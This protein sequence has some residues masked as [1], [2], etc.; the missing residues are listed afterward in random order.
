MVATNVLQ[1]HIARILPSEVYCRG[2]FCDISL[3]HAL[4]MA[5]AALHHPLRLSPL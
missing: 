1:F 5:P 2:M 4:T 3:D